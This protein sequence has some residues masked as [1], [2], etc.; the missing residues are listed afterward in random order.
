MLRTLQCFLNMWWEASAYFGVSWRCSS[1]TVQWVVAET[2]LT[3]RLALIGRTVQ[4]REFKAHLYKPQRQ[5]NNREQRKN[6]T[7]S[8]ITR[9]HFLYKL[10]L[11]YVLCS[12]KSA[13]TVL[14]PS[15][16]LSSRLNFKYTRFLLCFI[17]LHY[18]KTVSCIINML[19]V[20]QFFIRN[21]TVITF[22]LKIN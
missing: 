5:W 18:A 9:F 11:F 2:S 8:S 16:L 13:D 22:Q 7:C 4:A 6:V 12:C 1:S 17:L 10:A 21:L 14:I 20:Q 19:S 3:A 15:A